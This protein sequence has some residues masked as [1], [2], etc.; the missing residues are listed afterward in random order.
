MQSSFSTFSVASFSSWST[1]SSIAAFT[2]LT[3]PRISFSDRSASGSYG[4]SGGEDSLLK[5]T[6]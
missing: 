6:I 3:S 4:S 5:E 2:T 1:A